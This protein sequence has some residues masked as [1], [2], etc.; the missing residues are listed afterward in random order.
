MSIT[1]VTAFFDIGREN[2]K[3][4]PRTNNTYIENFKFWARMDNQLVVY[5][6]PDMSE[7]I[8]EIRRGFGLIE[9]T[10]IIE[11]EDI[12]LIEP[13]IL[14]KME[15]IRDN[16][17]FERF[18]ILP[19]ATSNIPRYSYLMFLKTWFL[20][21]AVENGYAS[22]NLVWFDFG[23]NHGGRLYT[24]PKEFA[25]EWNY[26]FSDKIHLF[27]YKKLDCKPIYETVRRLSDSI[28]GSPYV[29]PDH[30]CKTLWELT[31]ES[32]LHLV[33]VDLYDD[34]QLLLLMAYRAQP[35][36]FELH[37]SDWFWPL[38]EYGGNHLSVRR[39]RKRAF[40]KQL[41][42]NA[43]GKSKRLKLACRNA[44]ITFRDLYCKD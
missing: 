12:S 41:I 28:M 30:Y 14:K 27:Y 36:L 7:T 42:V 34:D 23:F 25:F 15:L 20:K 44:L 17:W 38:K 6:S 13:A 10:K 8:R 32:M 29:V 22:G 21:D 40:Y 11:I 18:R 43:L 24:E 16:G 9:K 4:I 37:E 39:P 1:L 2:F 26:D 31:R 3:A 5:T 35:D 19:D 33:S